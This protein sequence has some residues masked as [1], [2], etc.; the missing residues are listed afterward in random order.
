MLPLRGAHN[1]FVA[2]HRDMNLKELPLQIKGN[3]HILAAMELT[4]K[5]PAPRDNA[6]DAKFKAITAP[7]LGLDLAEIMFVISPRPR[8]HFM[9]N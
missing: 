2:I 6:G 4:D 5:M 1:F 9:R 7:S 3:N 8:R